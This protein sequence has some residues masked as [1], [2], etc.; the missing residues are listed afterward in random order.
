[1]EEGGGRREEGG[2]G[3]DILFK[4]LLSQWVHNTSQHRAL[5]EAYQRLGIEA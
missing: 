4:P 5:A 2:G 3:F 1:M